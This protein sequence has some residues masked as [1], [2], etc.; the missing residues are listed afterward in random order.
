MF[1]RTGFML[2]G[3]AV[4]ALAGCAQQQ[5]APVGIPPTFDKM[6]NAYCP[7]GYV[8]AGD[9]CVLPEEAVALGYS[10]DGNG[11][12]A[13]GPAGPDGTDGTDGTDADTNGDGG[14][15]GAGNTNRNRSNEQTNNRNQSQSGA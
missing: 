5:D 4:V 11:G 13:G 3:A 9:V 12:A 14:T 6:G 2:L 10:V 1:S 8:L 7:E 15:D